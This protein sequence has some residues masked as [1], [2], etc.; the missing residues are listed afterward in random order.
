MVAIKKLALYI[1]CTAII[2]LLGGCESELLNPKGMIAAQEK[3]ILILTTVLMLLIVIPVVVMT[4]LFAWR[5]RANN[6]KAKYEPDWSHNTK[7]EIIVWTIPCIMIAILGT[8]TWITS[9]TLDPYKPLEDSNH[10]TITIQA[11]AL[12]WKWLFIYPEQNIATINY[13]Q[14]PV[15]VPVRFLITAEGAMNCIQIPQLAGQIYAMAGMQT[16][17]HLVANHPGDYRGFSANFSGDGFADMNFKV[18]VGSMNEFNNWV[19]TVKR[20]S[21]PLTMHDFHHLIKPSFNNPVTLYS[22]ADEN[23][24]KMEIMKSMMPMS[25]AEMTH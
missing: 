24:Y 13:V 3:Q 18:H 1:I 15:D 2:L 22:S 8:I 25:H 11:I 6:A 12:D 7:L 19:K 4:L 21:T 16:K 17:L 20:S 5:Y 14:F 10:K 9:H 23:I